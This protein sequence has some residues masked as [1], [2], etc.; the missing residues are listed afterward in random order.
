MPE[1]AYFKRPVTLLVWNGKT[2][3]T[4]L[5]IQRQ[6]TNSGPDINANYY[7]IS[8]LFLDNVVEN[9]RIAEEQTANHP[10]IVKVRGSMASRVTPADPPVM[11]LN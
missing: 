5:H 7:E 1:F 8:G 2:E 11:R 4:L 3:T 10:A 9:V 6:V